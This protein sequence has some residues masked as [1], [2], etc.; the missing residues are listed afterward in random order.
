M[1]V[2]GFSADIE[3]LFGIAPADVISKINN[4]AKKEFFQRQRKIVLSCNMA[5]VD[6][7]TCRKNSRK[8]K[9]NKK[10]I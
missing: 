2:E 8:R 4:D 1:N 10:D 7:N 3:A 6:L 9:Q 5:W